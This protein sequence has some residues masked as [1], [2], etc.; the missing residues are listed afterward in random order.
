[1]LKRAVIPLGGRGTRLYP[2][3]VDTSKAMVRFLNRPL[4]EWIV[5]ELA[6]QGIREVY[7]AVSGFSNYVQLIDYM[8]GGE[9]IAI[10]LGPQRDVFRVRYMPNIVTSGN[11]QAVLVVMEYYDIED[12]VL[13]VQGDTVARIS[14]KELWEFHASENPFMTIVLKELEEWRDVSMYGVAE[15]AGGHRIARFVEKPA[16]REVPSRLVN[17][18]IYVLS[19]EFRDFFRSPVGTSMLVSG[20]TDFGRHV[21]P[22]VIELGKKVVGYVTRDYWFDVGTPES[23]LEAAFHLLRIL[24]DVELGVTLRYHNV[25][26][27]GRSVESRRMQDEIVKRFKA[28]EFEFYGDVLLGRH[29]SIGRNSRI[30]NSIIDHYCIIGNNVTIENSVV[31]DRC[32]ISDGSTVRNSIIG[33]HVTIGRNVVVSQSV[34]GND[35]RVEDGSVCMGSKVWPHVRIGEGSVLEN[36]SMVS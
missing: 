28:G 29:I 4:I 33:R 6:R 7:L 21:I 11:A 9:R 1:M 3:T 2:L 23:Y 25:R 34:L 24:D 18:G 10:R 13:V 35:V 31:M 8:G 16:G 36:V 14:L 19:H 30:S 27:Q 32:Y 20:E 5:V 17:T 26:M 15:L 22:A 12:P